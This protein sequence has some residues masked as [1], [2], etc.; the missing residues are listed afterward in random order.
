MKNHSHLKWILSLE[1]GFQVI[2]WS[3][4]WLSFLIGLIAWL[5]ITIFNW[6]TVVFWLIAL[7]FL[8]ISKTN[9]LHLKDGQLLFSFFGK[10]KKTVSLKNVSRIMYGANRSVTLLNYEE[11]ELKRFFLKPKSQKDFLAYISTHYPTIQIEEM[12]SCLEE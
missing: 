5:E 11:M 12:K 6:I 3:L 2:Y 1:P 8:F 9:Q 4:C 10:N 7:L